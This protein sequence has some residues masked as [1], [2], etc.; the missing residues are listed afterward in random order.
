MDLKDPKEKPCLPDEM[1]EKWQGIMNLTARTIGVPSALIVQIDEPQIEIV[2]SNVSEDNPYNKGGRYDLDTGLYCETVM[3]ER[4]PLLIPDAREDPL[5]TNSPE[6]EQGMVCYLGLP[7]LWPDGELFGTICVLDRRENPDVLRYQDLVWEFGQI[8]QSDLKILVLT[9]EREQT[10]EALN[11]SREYLR[12]VIDAS[13]IG[14]IHWKMNGAIV[15]ANDY[16]LEMIGYDR[17]DLRAGRIFWTRLTPSEFHERDLQVIAELRASGQNTPYEKIYIRKDGSRV[18]ILLSS[19]LVNH[20]DWDGVAFIIDITEQ[21]RSEALKQAKEIAEA[22]NRAKDQFLAMLSHELRTPLTPVLAAVT[23]LEAQ[24][25]PEL[26]GDMKLIRRNVEIEVAL[27]DDL[28]DVTRINY[29]KLQL[30]LETVDA[31][32]CL[33]S[34]LKMRQREITAKHLEIV[35]ELQASE[36][37]VEGDRTRLRQVFWNLLQNAIKFTPQGGKITLRTTSAAGHLK[38]EIIDTGAGIDPEVLP[39]VFNAFEQGEKTKNRRFGG[40]GLGLTIAKAMVDLHQGTLT[41]FSEGRNKGATFTVELNAIAVRPELPPSPLV[42]PA[43]REEHSLRILLV[44]DHRDTL[45]IMSRLLRKWGHQV[46]PADC[47][48]VALRLASKEKFDL[49]ISD[50]GL[51]DGSGLDIMRQVKRLYGLHGIAISG[52]GA[53]DDLRESRA[54]GFEQHLIKPV[55]FEALHSAVESFSTA[56]AV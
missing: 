9:A 11:A 3:A 12:R 54:A 41:A 52:Y 37:F 36:F 19:V 8:I 1:L 13:P 30:Q 26:Q 51:P 50:L 48:Q 18:P 23:A 27:I 32:E 42:V 10:N 7:L 6:L 25:D 33:L 4:K 53:D 31:H 22:S 39:R 29:G 45:Q 16:F 24:G 21:K 20:K 44:D 35:L 43:P 56:G 34:I 38:I 5:W 47:L 15:E 28:L 2:A 14:V 46:T 49:L 40:L 55:S 17:E